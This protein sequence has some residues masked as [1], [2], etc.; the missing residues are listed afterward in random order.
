MMFMLFFLLKP[1]GDDWDSQL[2]RYRC[3]EIMIAASVGNWRQP[4]LGHHPSHTDYVGQSPTANAILPHELLHVIYP[5]LHREKLQDIIWATYYLS[6]SK[7]SFLQESS[8]SCKM[9]SVLK[10][11]WCMVAVASTYRTAWILSRSA[12][13][14]PSGQKIQKSA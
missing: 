13:Q 10:C 6:V 7:P 12:Q 1:C 4:L 3:W 5:P 11:S 9:H 2:N 8:P 14:L